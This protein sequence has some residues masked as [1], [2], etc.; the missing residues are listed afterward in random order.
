MAD[1]TET[2]AGELVPN[3]GLT[4]LQREGA[5]L[6]AEGWSGKQI[7]SEL[8]VAPETVSRWRKLPA[9]NR[10]VLG[11]HEH[12]AEATRARLVQL[13]EQGLDKLEDLMNYPADKRIQ[14]RAAI[15]LLE[16]A[17]VQRVMRA[18][19]RSHDDTE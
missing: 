11:Y 12:A 5:R 2:P 14:L 16:L 8:Q 1:D 9:F 10:A 17:G 3:D 6:A 13:I 7:A 18:A 15:A 19:A 4:D